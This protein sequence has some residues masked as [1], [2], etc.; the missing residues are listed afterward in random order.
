[1]RL[2]SRVNV[3]DRFGELTAELERRTRSALDAAAVEAARVADEKANSP[4]PIA[5]FVPIRSQPTGEGYASGVHAGPLTRIFDKGSLAS[6][7]GAVKRARKPSWPVRRGANPYTA[8]RRSFD[9]GI[10][11]RNILS[12]ARK[13]GR[14]VLIARLIGH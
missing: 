3:T 6:H 5:H 1:M 11:P 8:Y 9:G 14:A 2:T 10:A 12:A 4:K 13:A 7:T